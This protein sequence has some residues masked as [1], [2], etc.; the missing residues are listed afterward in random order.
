MTGQGVHPSAAAKR[1]RCPECG[2]AS[3]RAD[4]S[5]RGFWRDPR[6]WVPGVVLVMLVVAELATPLYLPDYVSGLQRLGPSA[7]PC[8]LDFGDL[9]L[10]EFEQAAFGDVQALHR[11]QACLI[12]IANQ[13]SWSTLQGTDPAAEVFAA[14]QQGRSRDR[15][16]WLTL[17]VSCLGFP[18]PWLRVEDDHW[19]QPAFELSASE[20][21]FTWSTKNTR[22]G[23]YVVSVQWAQLAWDVGCPIFLACICGVL[24]R[25]R[26]LPSRR[27]RPPMRLVVFTCAVIGACILT[28]SPSCLVPNPLL[29]GGSS[30][31]FGVGPVRLEG[32]TLHALR[33]M[34]TKQDGAAR[35]AIMINEQ[36][37]ALVA[38]AV[39]AFSGS[40]SVAG[41]GAASPLRMREDL[42]FEVG[43]GCREVTD[44][45]QSCINFGWPGR[46][47]LGTLTM[48]GSP[49]GVPPVPGHCELE[50]DNGNGVTITLNKGA[51]PGM[52]LSGWIAWKQLVL[53]V[54]LIATAYWLVR[55]AISLGHGTRR[56]RRADRGC[57]I[58]CGYD[59]N[60][61]C[62][63]A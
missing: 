42:P 60:G 10:D 31:I 23:A 30:W 51:W 28:P 63:A 20:L 46:A 7:R 29:A 62:S 41:S 33:A 52:S 19:Y 39:A 5:P 47:T 3:Q 56:R 24:S 53:D 21:R 34:A 13:D 36:R 58:H 55:G 15:D 57:C 44:H 35:L 54:M 6:R 27:A 40:F 14:V 12:R 22:S 59:L 48:H 9:T 16:G 8:I 37:K 32:V 17:L 2:A 18:Q 25:H 1:V 26:R 4:A 45:V 61:L 50:F 43:I 49:K 38:A 11:I